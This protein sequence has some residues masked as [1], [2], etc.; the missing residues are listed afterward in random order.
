MM[1]YIEDWPLW[2]LLTDRVNSINRINSEEEQELYN[3]IELKIDEKESKHRLIEGYIWMVMKK[4][5]E[6]YVDC[7]YMRDDV[8]CSGLIT[9][10]KCGDK[11]DPTQGRSF[12]NYVSKSVGGAMW[13]R[14]ATDDYK[15]LRPNRNLNISLF[16]ANTP[17]QMGM[18]SS[19]EEYFEFID[20]LEDRTLISPED[21]IDLDNFLSRFNQELDRIF[22]SDLKTKMIIKC[23]YGL[24]IY[25]E[26]STYE[27]ARILG[28]SH[29]AIDWRK[30][31]GL[32]WI[33]QSSEMQ[34]LKDEFIGA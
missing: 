29:Q 34:R 16:S 11:F 5:A 10:C 14:M 27:V 2:E 4:A 24:G 25:K 15:P 3:K 30:K 17:I 26:I 31:K 20:T 23:C 32:R 12:I 9:L 33:K 8:L 22:E 13:R 1:K 28:V 6:L 7:Y 19:N 18:E 21:K